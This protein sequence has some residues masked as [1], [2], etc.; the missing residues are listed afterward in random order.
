MHDLIGRTL[1]QYRIIEQLGKGGMATVFKAF[2]P[3]LERYVA[4]KVLPPYFAHEDGFSQ[5]F[6]REAKAIAKLDH[7]HI[8]PIYD[9]GQ[10]GDIS[11]IAMKY[12]EAGTL[13]DC[14][15]NCPMSLEQAAEVISQTASALDYAH[16]QG[17]VHRDIKPANILLDRGQWVLLSDFGLARMVEGSQQLTASGVGVGTPAY[18]APEQGQGRRVDGRADIYS[19][20]IVLYE[21]LTG[22]VPYEAE[23]PLAVVLKHVTE[24]LKMPRLVNPEIPESVELVILKSLAKE[25]DDRYQTAGEMAT[26]L[27]NAIEDARF[28]AGD[29]PFGTPS[30]VEILRQAEQTATETVQPPIPKPEPLR[31]VPAATDAPADR[32]TVAEVADEPKPKPSKGKS[33]DERDK[34]RIPWWVYALGATV[35][36][37]LLAVGAGFIFGWFGA[38]D[39]EPTVTATVLVSQPTSTP[40]PA[41]TPTTKPEEPTPTTKP[42]EPSP[43]KQPLPTKEPPPREEPFVLGV[44]V[45]GYIDLDA[46]M[47][48]FVE[49]VT[50]RMGRPVEVIPLRDPWVLADLVRGGEVDA[51]LIYS[52]QYAWLRESEGLALKPLLYSEVMLQ[53]VVVVK[54]NGPIQGLPDLRGGRVAVSSWS[55]WGAILARWKAIEA[56]FRLEQETEIIYLA[57]VWE[58][59]L[60]PQTLE[61]VQ[62]GEADAAML[63]LQRYEPWAEE[64]PDHGLTIL[65]E[66]RPV[67]NGLLAFRPDLH[68]Q[69]VRSLRE[70]MLEIP[71]EQMG[72][73]TPF[74]A[75]FESDEPLDELFGQALRAIEIDPQQLVEAGWPRNGPESEPVEPPST[76]LRV[77]FVP[78]SGIDPQNDPFVIPYRKVLERSSEQLGYDLAIATTPQDVQPLDAAMPYVEEGYQV[79][80]AFSWWDTGTLHEL[81]Q[82]HP[83]ITV[84]SVGTAPGEIPPNLIAIVY[85]YQ[86]AGFLA[87]AVAGWAAESGQVA[88]VAGMEVDSVMRLA[89]GFQR[90]VEYT[91]C[92]CQAHVEMAGDFGN[93]ELGREIGHRLAQE[94]TRVVFNAAGPLGGAAIRAAARE[95]AWA[96]GVD[97]DEFKTTFQNGEVPGAERLLGS[98][99]HRGELFLA[100]IMADL[101]RGT[102]EPGVL[103]VGIAEGAT[104]FVPGRESAHPNAGA[105]DTY[106][107]DLAAAVREGRVQP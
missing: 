19:L 44:W 43:T 71:P 83:D 102:F 11:Y 20:G 13:K 81:A 5:R 105:L 96:I 21:M 22:R 59:D 35:I 85:R 58:A 99:V 38:D 49:H 95:G 8:L 33:E 57:P 9:F 61:M 32:P 89:E 80:V 2:Q 69:E 37:A 14:D 76:E 18:M 40:K 55:D 16:E 41:E 23:T 70:A 26:R 27:C 79:I 36:V 50:N 104:E 53:G 12:V 88:I 73:F 72:G 56:D 48:P 34:R 29:S 51:V 86:D 75:L 47:G 63:L 90:G 28:L 93:V 97:V 101:V 100:P 54:E 65:A 94:G 52:T 42:D 39:L 6:V 45:R 7:P 1:G 74:G 15:P 17:V 67:P 77:A 103:E 82:A 98:I 31:Q 78:N 91:G 25:P 84:I 66:S 87:G 30:T 68:A 4:I 60:W 46:A 107:K 106:I 10:D 24:P 64:Q 62:N 3:S 92:D